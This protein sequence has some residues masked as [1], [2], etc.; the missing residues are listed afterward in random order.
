M[1]LRDA[2]IG[3]HADYVRLFADL[4][5]PDPPPTPEDFAARMAPRMFILDDAGVVAGFLF[6]EIAGDL[7]RVRQIVID[8][9]Y[10]RQG[11]GLRLMEAAAE[12]FRVGACARWSLN[13]KPDN[14]G[15]R[16]LYGGLGLKDGA[17]SVVFRFGGE[18]PGWPAPPGLVFG[19]VAQ[20]DDA[21]YA[22]ALG[23][24]LAKMTD[25]RAFAGTLVH[26]VTVE[27]EPAGWAATDPGLPFMRGHWARPETLGALLQGVQ[28][29][30]PDRE[31]RFLIGNPEKRRRLREAGL[32]VDLEV[33][34]MEGP[35]PPRRDAGAGTP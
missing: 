28:A 23:A 16:A 3:D 32:P 1:I 27:G 2:H 11:L 15:A 6:W 8:S 12:R 31:L 9:R 18:L 7:G 5:V 22:E 13:V 25:Y 35:L 17:E 14:R 26:G 4:G 24:S 10:R 34:E 20:A 30:W 33:L 21:R 19:E 29:V